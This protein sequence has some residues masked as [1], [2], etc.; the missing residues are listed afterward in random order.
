MRKVMLRLEEID[1][2]TRAEDTEHSPNGT[3]RTRTL[4]WPCAHADA[5][6]IRYANATLRSRYANA[7]A[8]ANATPTPTLTLR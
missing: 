4:V 8:N 1:S 5:A 3:A 7:N 6:L 2:T